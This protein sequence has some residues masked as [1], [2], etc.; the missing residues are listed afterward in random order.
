VNDLV[1]FLDTHPTHKEALELYHKYR[2][3][4]LAAQYEYAEKYGPMSVNE[5]LSENDWTWVRDKFPW[6]G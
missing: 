3:L 6:E 1:L 5:V 2:N 4:Y